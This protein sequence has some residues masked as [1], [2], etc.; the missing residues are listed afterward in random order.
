MGHKKYTAI[1]FDLDGTLLEV[2]D[3]KKHGD[4][5]IKKTLTDFNIKRTR[6]EDRI[7]FW[8]SGGGF[9]NLLEKWGIESE[10]E[11]RSFLDT[12]NQNEY[13]VKKRL[14][15]SGEVRAY[16]DS[17]ILNALRGDLKL[18]LVTNSSS[19][20]VSFELN[21][22]NLRKCFS[23]TI[24]LGDFANNLR[25]K[26][27][28]DGIL[29]CLKEMGEAPSESLVVGDSLTDIIAGN[30]SQTSTALLIREKKSEKRRKEEPVQT[31][32][33]FRLRSLMELENIIR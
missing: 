13:N 19:K 15:E 26:P 1:I 10:S 11:K 6:S 2:E 9:L 7:R 5:I 32:I 8:F 31:R 28:P 29:Q 3:I 33:D 4:E 22:F 14:I 24:A 17:K 16:E 27:D 21:R 18:G 30:R 12:L 20:T 23:S 25:P